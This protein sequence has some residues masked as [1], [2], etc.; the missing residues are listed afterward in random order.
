MP[1]FTYHIRLTSGESERGRLEA[2]NESAAVAELR[3]RNALVLEVLPVRER[4]SPSMG[5]WIPVRQVHVELLL[6]QLAVMLRNGMTLLEALSAAQAQ[7]RH[8]GIRR[9]LSAVSNSIQQGS[10]LGDAFAG[11]RAIPALVVQ[12]VRVGEE[13]GTLEAVLDQAAGTLERTRRLRGDILTALLYPIGVFIITM[14]VATFMVL[15]TLPRISGM[16]QALGRRL[17]PMTQAML[18]ISD[19]LRIW[20]PWALA[21]V[22][23]MV[24][25][26]IVMRLLPNGRRLLGRILFGIPIIGHLLRLGETALFGR[27]LG[28]MLSSGVNL[29]DGLRS[30]ENLMRNAEAAHMVGEARRRVLGGGSLASSL[31]CRRTFLPL[32]GSM[33]GIGESSGTLDDVLSEV[34]RFAE[35]DLQ[36]QVKLFSSMVGP[37]TIVLVGLVVGFVYMSFFLALFAAAGG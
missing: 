3:R 29:V 33:V 19:A 34:A 28:A 35:Q 12:L 7:S 9:L 21:I 32:L 6:G 27:V 24:G 16:L 11:Q 18:D 4:Q 5:A 8:P 30:T 13:S 10:S 1:T 15:V 2:D 14:G 37:V 36:R 17:P 31:E 22:V 23:A 20:M 26:V 25:G